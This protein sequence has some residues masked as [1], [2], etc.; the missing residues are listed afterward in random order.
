MKSVLIPYLSRIDRRGQTG[1]LL[2]SEGVDEVEI[3][4]FAS[5][6]PAKENADHAGKSDREED[7]PSAA[8]PDVRW[9]HLRE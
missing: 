5:R 1:N 7:R 9:L 3:R 6:I 4:G 2:V 8:H